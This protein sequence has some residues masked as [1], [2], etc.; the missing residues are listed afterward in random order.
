[1]QDIV[2][3]RSEL[4]NYLKKGEKGYIEKQYTKQEIL[5]KEFST[6]S[7]SI[8]E[9]YIDSM[10]TQYDDLMTDLALSTEEQSDELYVKGI[11]VDVD[12]QQGYSILHIQNKDVNKS[13][14]CSEA[15]V[16]KYGKYFETGH[17]IIVK[18]NCFG[19][20]LYMHFLIDLSTKDP[21]ISE[22]NYINGVSYELILGLDIKHAG[23]VKQAVYFISG[24]GNKCLR[25][26]LI[27][28]E[29]IRTAITCKTGFNRYFPKNIVAGTFVKYEPSKEV[30]VNN[31]QEIIP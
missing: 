18:C 21:F 6:I 14:S 20:K 24:P 25:M 28:K 11:I 30:F 29:G 1:M 9:E 3:K 23:L 12:N 5:N 27:T 7:F 16:N 10:Q 19:N 31:V 13:I 8:R 2:N 17:V 4:L 22:Y 26:E 15:V